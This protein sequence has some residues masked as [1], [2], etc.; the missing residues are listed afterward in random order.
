MIWRKCRNGYDTTLLVTTWSAMSAKERL[1][2]A[3][4]L[5]WIRH[6]P[7]R[8]SHN[9]NS[10]RKN[11]VIRVTTKIKSSSEP[12]QCGSYGDSRVRLWWCYPNAYRSPTADR[13]CAVLLFIFGTTC[14]QL[15]ERSSDTFCR[16]HPSFCRT[17]L[18]RM[19]RKLWLICS[20]DGAGKCCTI[21]HTP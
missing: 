11:G 12:Q 2:Y 20:I 1:S 7:N 21:H 3:V 5:R 8:A 6:G 16:T 17:M 18:G 14:N 9:W 4:P 15:W 19:Q 13:Q 10:N